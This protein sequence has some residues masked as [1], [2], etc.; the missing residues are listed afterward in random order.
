MCPLTFRLIRQQEEMRSL[1]QVVISVDVDE[2]DEDVEDELLLSFVRA[3]D[4]TYTN[5]T[6]RPYFTSKDRSLK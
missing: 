1:L 5:L 2:D 3:L 6:V 4:A